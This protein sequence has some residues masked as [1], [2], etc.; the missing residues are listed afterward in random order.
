MKLNFYGSHAAE[1]FSREVEESTNGVIEHLMVTD[2][3]DPDR[4]FTPVSL[5]GY[6]WDD[7]M[8]SRDAGTFLRELVLWGKIHEAKLLCGSLIDLVGKNEEGYYMYPV[9]FFKGKVRAGTE[10]DGTGAVIIGMVLLWQ[11]LENGDV[12][13]ERIEHFLLGEGSPAMC[14]MHQLEKTPLLAGT[15]EFGGGCDD[16]EH[17]NVVQNNLMR[18]SMLAVAKLMRAKGDIAHAEQCEGAAHRIAEGIRKY[19][20]DENGCYIWCVEPDTMQPDPAV[21]GAEINYGAGLLNGVL[22]MT[23][24]VCGLDPAADDGFFDMAAMETTFDT[25]HNMPP[26]KEIFDENGCWVQFIKYRHGSTGPSYGQGYAI[27]SMLLLNRTEMAGKAIKFMAEATYDLPVEQTE[28]VRKSPYYFLERIYLPY[29]VEMGVDLWCGCGEIN[30]VNVA[31]P[32]KVARMVAGID[33]T[34]ELTRLIPRLPEGFD[35]FEATDVPFAIQNGVLYGDLI[36]KKEQNG[37]RFNLKLKESRLENVELRWMD[38]KYCAQN[39]S[40][41]DVVL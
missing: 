22:S 12:M 13:K 3:N 33:S 28:L 36:C 4:G 34:P 11:R 1:L 6:P 38:K 27:Q 10:L 40:E 15:G 26:R 18:L 30:L 19:L 29:S 20:V 5:P 2:E 31:E 14:I 23:A 17:I 39:V 8:W 32:M 7:T 16:N 9:Y 41:L 37:L 35:G 25:L 21:I 24:D